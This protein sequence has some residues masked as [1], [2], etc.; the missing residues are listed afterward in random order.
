M[1]GAAR[2]SGGRQSRL[3][4]RAR[5]QGESGAV[6]ATLA[7]TTRNPDGPAL[8]LACGALANE[9]I[10]LRKQLGVGEDALVLHC[11]PAE[12]HNRP[13]QI[14]PRVDEFL[15]QHREKYSQVLIGYGDCGT[16]GALDAVLTRHDAER[17]PHA[18]CYEF[19]ATS[20][21]FEDIT[22]AEV[23]SFFVTD[24]LV[25]H[26]DR[27]IWEGLALDRHPEMLESLFGNY[28]DLVYLAQADV[29]LLR[30]KAKEAADRLGLNYVFR[31]VGYGDLASAVA[32]VA[33]ESGAQPHV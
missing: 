22:E 26:F 23:G 20:P 25:K 13:A 5:P 30:I 4:R 18:H 7:T 17:L 27:L 21:V 10:A 8:I 16:G 32:A 24:F 29:P 28:R 9:I 11:L 14:A 12:L 2:R 15:A 19:Y 1:S 33:R 3:A 31:D 6:G